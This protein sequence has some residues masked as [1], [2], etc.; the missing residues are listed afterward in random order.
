MTRSTCCAFSTPLEANT[1]TRRT[2][3]DRIDVHST[4]GALASIHKSDV[5]TSLD[6]STSGALGETSRTGAPAKGTTEE[7]GE[8]V[9]LCATKS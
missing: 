5:D 9:A 4:K 3:R 8:Q 6:I 2:G 1:A 7:L